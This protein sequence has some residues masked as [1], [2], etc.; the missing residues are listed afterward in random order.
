[1]HAIEEYARGQKL[2]RTDFSIAPLCPEVR[3]IDQPVPNP[4]CFFGVND[5]STQTWMLKLSVSGGEDELWRGLEH[6]SRKQINK[7]E[8]AGLVAEIVTPDLQLLES[9]YDLHLQTC[10]RN[11]IAPHPKEYFEAIFDSVAEQGLCKTCVV[12]FEGKVL[13]VQNFLIYKGTALYWTVASSEDALKRCANDYGMWAA[14]KNFN[15]LGMEYLECGE[16]FPAVNAGK[17]R[18]LNDFK[19]SF[20]G[21]LF[22]YYRGSIYHRPLIEGALGMLRHCRKGGAAT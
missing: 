17:R 13:T 21:Q 8:R 12:R 11:G 9:Y 16:A 6:R 5:A 7:A 14:I 2:R 3:A 19:K 22:P 15:R 1:L 10:G 20:G 18:G 4:L